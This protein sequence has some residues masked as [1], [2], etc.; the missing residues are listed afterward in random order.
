M[1]F[2]TYSLLLAVSHFDHTQISNSEVES[3]SSQCVMESGVLTVTGRGV[4]DCITDLYQ[5]ITELNLEEGITEIPNGSCYQFVDLTK[6]VLASTLTALG[7]HAFRDCISLSEIIMPKLLKTIGDWCFCNC[8]ALGSAY[9]P[10]NGKLLEISSYAFASCYWLENTSFPVG[11][12]SFGF[13][14]FYDCR[15]LSSVTLYNKVESIGGKCFCY[16]HS[17]SNIRL[18]ES[19]AK[20]EAFAFFNCSSLRTV[21]IPASVNFIGEGSFALS[22]LEWISIGENLNNINGSAFS[23]CEYLNEIR[24]SGLTV[25]DAICSV[26]NYSGTPDLPVLPH[27]DDLHFVAEQK[28]FSQTIVCGRM[29]IHVPTSGSPLPFVSISPSD[30]PTDP[31]G[32]ISKSKGIAGLVCGILVIL[33]L[34]GFGFW[35]FK[36]RRRIST[37]EQRDELLDAAEV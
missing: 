33:G 30:T 20:I 2:L 10:V 29:V 26:L 17:L 27:R 7:A 31:S 21:V 4:A 5:N 1:L 19:L 16:C 24:L 35:W 32:K 34:V 23:G 37:K 36:C 15:S 14:A 6:V 18:S 25:D 28:D 3:N 22:H 11:L 13:A 12:V 9:F 8:S